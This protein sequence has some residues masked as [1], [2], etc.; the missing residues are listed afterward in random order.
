ML[1]N[2][3]RKVSEEASEQ[4]ARKM[5]ALEIFRAIKVDLNQKG[6]YYSKLSE[7]VD[8]YR[9]QMA[10]SSRPPPL[11]SAFS[12]YGEMSKHVEC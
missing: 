3:I 5:K 2:G 1:G 6:N 11:P 10:H 7:N 8:I 9:A 4:G 12:I